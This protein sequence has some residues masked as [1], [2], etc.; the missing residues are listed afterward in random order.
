MVGN[1]VELIVIDEGKPLGGSC[2]RPARAFLVRGRAPAYVRFPALNSASVT[3]G[4]A[5]AVSNFRFS[6][7]ATDRA[8]LGTSFNV[9]TSQV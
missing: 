7:P 8:T 5:A 4:F 6:S 2:Y 1:R 3:L 9:L